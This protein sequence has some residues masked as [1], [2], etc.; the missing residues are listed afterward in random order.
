MPEIATAI[1]CPADRQTLME[2][3]KESINHGLVFG[4]PPAI[5]LL[6]HPPA[7]CELR[8]TFTT[9]E[10]DHRLRGCIGT[11]TAVRPLITDVAHNSYGA[12]FR[13]P[14]FPPVTAQEI[15]QLSIHLSILSPAQPMTFASEADLLSQLRPRI[16]GLI[17][18]EESSPGKERRATFLPAVWDSLP[19]AKA[20]LSHLKLK[21]GLATDYWSDKI[22]ASRYTTESVP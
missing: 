18:S 12:A 2:M 11:L 9:L 6:E 15:K 19:D 16:D 20:F 13:D 21:A 17:L 14:R 10:I 5:F 8:A 22:K 1:L 3:A 7:L 4:S